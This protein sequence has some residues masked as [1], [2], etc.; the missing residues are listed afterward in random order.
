MGRYRWRSGAALLVAFVVAT[1]GCS[2]PLAGQPAPAPDVATEAT[3]PSVDEVP[4]ETEALPAGAEAGFDDLNQDGMPDPTCSRQDYGGG[5]V[6]RV[7]CNIADYASTPTEDTVL[8]PNSLYGFPGTDLDLSG[9]SGQAVQARN[10]DGLLVVVLFIT[11][12]TLFDV[13]SATLGEPAME[14]FGN[15]VALIQA[16]WPTAQVQVRG[17]TDATGSAA[18]NQTLSE[19]RAAA[20]LEF[21]ANNGI[22]RSQ[23][24]SIG[25]GFTQPLVLETNADG[26]VNPT[27]QQYNRRVEFAVTIP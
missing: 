17:H 15:V 7:L 12:D 9:I 8:V 22:S 10:A 18:G 3:E 5:L 13:G 2:A 4:E 19:N 16:N 1:A 24:S 6:L 25:F 26:S 20:A 11:S 21:F 14:S 27:G 23:L